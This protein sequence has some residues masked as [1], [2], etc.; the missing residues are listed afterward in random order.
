MVALLGYQQLQL[1]CDDIAMIMYVLNKRG[2]IKRTPEVVVRS[3][4]RHL[5]KEIVSRGLLF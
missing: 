5:G 2:F 1:S 4:Y 3:V